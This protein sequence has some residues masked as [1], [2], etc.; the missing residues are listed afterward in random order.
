MARKHEGGIIV[1]TGFRIENPSPIDDRLV[2]STLSDLTDPVALP[3]I[4]GGILV[5]VEDSNYDLYKWNGNDRTDLA[6]WSVFSGGTSAGGDAD[7]SLSALS[8]SFASNSISSSF[9]STSS[10]ALSSISASYATTASHALN[11]FLS[12]TSSFALTASH[13]LNLDIETLSNVTTLFDGNRNVTNAQF[14]EMFGNNPYV[15]AYGY[16]NEDSSSIT[17]FLEAV[18]YPPVPNK[19]PL[20]KSTN[21]ISVNEFTV[22]KSY[23]HSIVAEDQAVLGDE[24]TIDAITV[25]RTQSIYTDDFFRRFSFRKWIFLSF[26]QFF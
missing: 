8:A 10:I 14:P 26:F 16:F 1:P 3:N 21:Q 13:I 4:Y 5:A 19:P 20:I 11:T 12:T 23:V 7:S 9:A 6:N 24:S 2:V 18:F 22:S 15:N 17:D 25:F